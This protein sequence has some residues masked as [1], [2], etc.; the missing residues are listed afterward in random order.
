MAAPFP[1][2]C[3]Y[4]SVAIQSPNGPFHPWKHMNSNNYAKYIYKHYNLVEINL[5]NWE[6]WGEWG[7]MAPGAGPGHVYEVLDYE[8]D[9]VLINGIDLVG[10]DEEA[11]LP[12]DA[13]PAF[14]WSRYIRC[15]R[16]HRIPLLLDWQHHLEQQVQA[17]NYL[18]LNPPEESHN[19]FIVSSAFHHN[20]HQILNANQYAKFIYKWGH[21]V[22]FGTGSEGEIGNWGFQAAQWHFA[23]QSYAVLSQE[24]NYVLVI[25]AIVINE[26]VGVD[27]DH[28]PLW[29]WSKFLRVHKRLSFPRRIN[30]NHAWE[31]HPPMPPPFGYFYLCRPENKEE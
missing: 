29:V 2:L 4:N 23:N 13:L 7:S 18:R 11:I 12:D 27:F 14:V 22:R 3:H 20:W 15:Y 30:W 10:E 26:A 1:A 21:T 28:P 6:Q 16:D 19:A 25:Q 24:D 5:G 9:Y 17:V 31:P 8:N